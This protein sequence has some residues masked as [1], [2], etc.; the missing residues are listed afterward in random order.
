MRALDSKQV[1]KREAMVQFA[2]VTL[3]LFPELSRD[4][5]ADMLLEKYSLIHF[6]YAT[7]LVDDAKHLIAKKAFIESLSNKTIA[8]AKPNIVIHDDKQ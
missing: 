2:I 4:A 6:Q 7:L 8:G 1:A 3:T 5:V